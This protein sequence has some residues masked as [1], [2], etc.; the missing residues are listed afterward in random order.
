MTSPVAYRARMTLDPDLAPILAMLAD[1]PVKFGET[2]IEETRRSYDATAAFTQVDGGPIPAD[3]SDVTLAGRP[4]R[5]YR[6]VEAGERPRATVLFLHGGGWVTGSIVSHDQVARRL[7]RDTGAVVVSLDYRLAPE[8]PFPAAVDDA[9]AAAREL[10]GDLARWGGAPVLGV[11]GDSAGGNLAAVVSQHVDE[12]AAQ[13]LIYPSVDKAGEHPSRAENGTGYLLETETMHWFLSQYVPA[14]QPLDD[15]RLSPLYGV[16]AGLAPAVVVTAGFD[17]LRDEGIAYA[18]ALRAAGNTVDAVN[19]EG[20]IHGFVDMG[21]FSAA[22]EAAIAD[23][24]RRFKQLLDAQLAQA[25]QR[26]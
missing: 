15:P 17:P 2:P 4:A 19:H 18:E 23:M 5:A 26:G 6:P 16:R 11:A 13:L 12:V 9:I 21:K 10:A 20:L 7:C 22:A 3:V 1:S 24:N 25:P 14:G 8:H